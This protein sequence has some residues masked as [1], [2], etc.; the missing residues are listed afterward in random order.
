MPNW[1]TNTATLCHAEPAM[2]E[3]LAR[4]FRED[5]LLSEFIPVP[6]GMPDEEAYHF[7]LTNWGTKWDV[8]G[9]VDDQPT[10]YEIT[11]TFDSAWSPPIT[12]YEKL[13]S[14]GFKVKAYYWEPGMSFCGVFDGDQNGSAT[15]HRDYADADDIRDV[16]GEELDD[17]YGISAEV[18]EAVA[19]WEDAELRHQ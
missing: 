16:V 15:D 10:P 5:R 1:C 17:F 11:V 4:A 6:E 12:G 18:E 9:E 3:R 14:L 13:C 8:G 7:R 2:I 19:D